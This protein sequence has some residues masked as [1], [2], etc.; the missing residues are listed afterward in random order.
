MMRDEILD[1]VRSTVLAHR[2]LGRGERVL[3]AVSGGPDSVM[4]LHV[5]LQLRAE[6]GLILHVA[7]L[8]HA[9]RPGS[10]EDA[11]F[12]EQMGIREG[13]PMTIERQDV[14]RL[15]AE[16]GWSIEDGARRIR[17]EFL[18]RVATAERS[19]RVALAHTADDQAETVLMRLV[20]GTGVM[21][22]GAIPVTRP[23]GGGRDKSQPAVIR[24]L[25]EIWRSEVLAYLRD[26]GLAYREDPSNADVRFLRN[27]VRRELLPLLERG[28]NPNIK[29]S[30]THLAEQSRWDY[31]FLSHAARRQWKRVAKVSAPAQVA[32]SIASLLRQPKA[33]QRQLIRQA[34]E[35]VQ[36]H[37]RQFEFR[38]WLEVERLLTEQPPGSEVDLP[39]G[40]RLTRTRDRLLC[41]QHLASPAA[42]APVDE[43]GA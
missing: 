41:R 42:A 10:A 24:P 26:A 34:V 21:G 28:Y 5:L 32:V 6:L 43:E 11:G 19:V 20:R 31:A 39:G 40:V 30:L 3:V 17:Y 14:G 25:L 18:L 16:R 12:V 13:L 33:I 23:L 29:R 15:S 37:L 9:L 8:D 36:G 1:R 22:L 38:H 27:R 2:L 7:H 35:A 4:L